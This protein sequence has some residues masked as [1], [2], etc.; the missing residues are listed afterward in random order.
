M[1]FFQSVVVLALASSSPASAQNLKGSILSFLSGE[2]NNHCACP[3]DIKTCPDG[4]E[5]VRD[6]ELDCEF[7]SCNDRDAIR[8]ED[9]IPDESPRPV[10]DGM[11]FRFNLLDLK[12]TGGVKG[13]HSQCGD[14]N[15]RLYEY[16]EVRGEVMDASECAEK[17]VNGVTDY[18]ADE[19]LGFD[20]DCEY[21]TCRCLYS[22]G[23]IE[24]GPTE[25]TRAGRNGFTR[26]N[27]NYDGEGSITTGVEKRD[28]EGVY[29][30]KLVGAEY[31]E[32][33]QVEVA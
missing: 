20:Y 25:D 30:F 16:G 21:L 11:R 18:L 13:V 10:R 23:T 1:N 8:D 3:Y 5:L 28:S 12:N 19:L 17:C 2:T 22:A 24:D 14:A 26:T 4:R 27:T 33:V 15:R 31:L 29:C 6:C 7:P 32:D 9:C